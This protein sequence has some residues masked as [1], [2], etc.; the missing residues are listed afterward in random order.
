M[1]K[2]LKNAVLSVLALLVMVSAMCYATD[3]WVKEDIMRC[4]SALKSVGKNP[5][6]CQ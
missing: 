1:L 5:K 3:A 4:E 2:F 6:A